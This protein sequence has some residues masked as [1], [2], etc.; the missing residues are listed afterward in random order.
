[1]MINIY[2]KELPFTVQ[3]GQVSDWRR[4]I[5]TSLPSPKDFREVGQEQELRSLTYRVH[6]RSI[7]VLV[8]R[9]L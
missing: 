1:M 5:D 3:E 7:V 4:V 6:A 2:W 9:T 8:R